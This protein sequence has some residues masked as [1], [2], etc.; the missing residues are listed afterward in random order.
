[1]F[2]S[3]TADLTLS[4]QITNIIPLAK[5]QG[6]TRGKRDVICTPCRPLLGSKKVGLIGPRKLCF[7]QL[8]VNVTVAW[9]QNPALS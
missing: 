4:C 1:M 5:H 6:N 8:I 2:L 3:G 9:D 7:A